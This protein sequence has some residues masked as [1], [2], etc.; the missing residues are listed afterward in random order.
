[1]AKFSE[2]ATSTASDGAGMWN[3]EFYGPSAQ[4]F[5]NADEDTTATVANTTPSGVAGEFNASSTY[6]S[7]VG[8]FAAERE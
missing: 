5:E 4:D 6:T 1:M 8:A 2:T 7:V 3:A